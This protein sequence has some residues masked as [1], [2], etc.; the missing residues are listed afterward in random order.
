MRA[1]SW[2]VKVKE[3]RSFANNYGELTLTENPY[4]FAQ[5]LYLS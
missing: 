4:P 1:A 2:P 5:T 3:L